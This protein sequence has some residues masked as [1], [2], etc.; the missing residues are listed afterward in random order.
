M[1]RKPGGDVIALL[2]ED[3]RDVEAVGLKLVESFAQLRDAPDAVGSPG[4]AV[5]LD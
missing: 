4:A 1:L 3:D 2:A 5:K